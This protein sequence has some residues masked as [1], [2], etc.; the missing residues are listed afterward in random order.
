MFIGGSTIFKNHLGRV[1]KIFSYSSDLLVGY[2][3]LVSVGL[4]WAGGICSSASTL[5]NPLSDTD[6]L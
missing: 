2:V 1:A 4:L 5:I 3:R 6:P